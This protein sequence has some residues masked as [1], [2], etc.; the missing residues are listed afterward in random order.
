MNHN[1]K[2][3]FK[4]TSSNGSLGES[5]GDKINHEN[6]VDGVALPRVEGNETT[7]VSL[8]GKGDGSSLSNLII[9]QILSAIALIEIEMTLIGASYNILK[10]K[11]EI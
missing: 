3:N 7:S 5:E 8:A 4:E 9:Y 1:P 11:N 2:L 6:G 10:E